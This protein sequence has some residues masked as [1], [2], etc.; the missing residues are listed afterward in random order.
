MKIKTILIA[1][2]ISAGISSYGQDKEVYSTTIIEFPFTWS[3]ANN[4][5]D[6]Q[7]GPVRF[8][9]FFNFQNNL[10]VDFS[11]KA[12]LFAGLGIHNVGFIFDVDEYTRVKVRSYNLGIPI[13][14]KI[15]NMDKSHIY[16]G[17]EIEFP[18]AFKQ[19]TFVNE[20]KSKYSKWFS[21]QT[22]IQ[23]SWMVGVQLPG[24]ANVKFKYYFTNFFNEDYSMSDGDGGSYKP[25]QDFNANV[26][27]ISLNM[28]L[29]R[30][31]DLTY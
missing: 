5:G 30:N 17:Y 15:G 6:D 12:G 4:I 16:G 24:G 26:F 7:G 19:K 27:W 10:N 14:F 20:E 8:A 13:G 31:S 1:L 9:P 29:L 3:N 23:Q 25:Y 11:E 22:Q 18:F 28:V 2:F 21:D